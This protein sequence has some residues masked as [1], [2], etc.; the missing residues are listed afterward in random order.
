VINPKDVMVIT[1]AMDG[2]HVSAYTGGMCAAFAQGLL[3]GL[4][5]L[6]GCSDVRLAR[7]LTVHKFLATRF[8]WLLMV[9]ADIGFS[10]TDVR[11]MLGH[12]L[13]DG[14]DFKPDVIDLPKDSPPTKD[15]HGNDLLVVAEYARKADGP[16]QIICF[17]L[18]FV[19][20]AR[21][22]FQRVIDLTDDS[23]K[24]LVGSFRALDGS[25]DV[26]DIF[27]SGPG[28]NGAYATEDRGFFFLCQLAGLVPRVE[29]R[30][31]LVHYGFHQW[32][33]DAKGRRPIEF[34]FNPRDL[35]TVH[36]DAD[37]EPAADV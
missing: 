34:T 12:P 24:P 6:D 37:E 7:S 25:G 19:L 36:L 18:G 22:A 8:K 20:V 17:G 10:H 21:E 9:D 14:V 32:N 16:A 33:Y 27:P 28:M 31:K 29:R 1:P 4:S 23:G 35:P 3:G 5:F 11:L 26:P 13:V 30:T 2:K 15:A